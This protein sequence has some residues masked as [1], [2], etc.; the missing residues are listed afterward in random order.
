[1][2]NDHWWDLARHYPVYQRG[3]VQETN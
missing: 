2:S 3:G 1:M